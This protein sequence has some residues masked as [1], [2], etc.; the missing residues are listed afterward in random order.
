[1]RK[2]GVTIIAA[3]L[4]LVTASPASAVTG[5]FGVAK[6]LRGSALP[7]PG[8][9]V[10]RGERTP[11]ACHADIASSGGWVKKTG[12]AGDFAR[13]F[14]PVACEQPPRSQFLSPDA[15]KHAT[16]AALSVIG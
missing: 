16:A 1:M 5:G 4:V 12:A 14:A 7:V 11:S 10:K 2:Q 8:A 15:L 3:I 9:A 6:A 13:K